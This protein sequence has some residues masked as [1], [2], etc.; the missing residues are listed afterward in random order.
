MNKEMGI[1]VAC[2]VFAA[3]TGIVMDKNNVAWTL[4]IW[5][6]LLVFAVI[7][8]KKGMR[9]QKADHEARMQELNKAITEFLKK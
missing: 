8:Y 5:V 1:S 7:F 9:K 3:I 2:S 6:I 4:P